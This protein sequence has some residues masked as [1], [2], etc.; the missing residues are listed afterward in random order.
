MIG[1]KGSENYT[2]FF[3][4]L[5]VIILINLASTTFFF[6]VDL[7][8]NNS[9]SI[10]KA[11]KEV[12][13]TLSEPLTINVFFT[14]NL[15]APH[16]STEQYIRDLLEEYSLSSNQFF[17]YRFFDV[18]PDEGDT[19]PEAKKN[20]ELARSYGVHPIQ[21]QIVDNDEVKFQKAYMGLVIIHGD[22]I[23]RIPTIT[24]TEMLE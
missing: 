10:S 3:I 7:T 4:Y 5:I 16:N 6:R 18:S 1:K 15:P 14:K 23:E 19:T 9:Y 22:I 2:K 11:S 13:S 24:S 8:E 17:N 12:V 20:Q 21:I